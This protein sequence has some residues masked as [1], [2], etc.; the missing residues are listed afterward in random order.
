VQLPCDT[1]EDF[2]TA[3]LKSMDLLVQLTLDN[4][5][6]AGIAGGKELAQLAQ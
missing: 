5:G 3:L 6:R 1:Y 4:G 2:G